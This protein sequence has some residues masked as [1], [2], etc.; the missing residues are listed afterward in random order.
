[1]FSL[2]QIRKEQDVNN[3]ETPNP[4]G[5]E[6]IDPSIRVLDYFLSNKSN[7]HHNIGLQTRALL[8]SPY[9]TR[10]ATYVHIHT[11]THTNTKSSKKIQEG[12]RGKRSKEGKGGGLGGQRNVGTEDQI[13][14]SYQY[15]HLDMNVFQSFIAC[16]KDRQ[17]KKWHSLCQAAQM[18]VAVLS[19]TL[20]RVKSNRATYYHDLET[21]LMRCQKCSK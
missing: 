10:V 3:T 13:R 14:T 19:H 8:L 1:M 16:K 6:Q 21:V 2:S 12:F 5:F 15:R 20:V 17:C 9:E 4:D 11:H 18:L 7:H